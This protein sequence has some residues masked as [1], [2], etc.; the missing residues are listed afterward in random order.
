MMSSPPASVPRRGV[1]GRTRTSFTDLVGCTLPLQLAGMGEISTVRLAA[2]VSDAGGLGMLGAAGR[3]AAELG[4]T[5][6]QLSAATSGAFGV[7]FLMPFL[8]VDAV[9]LAASICRVVEFFYGEPDSSLVEI[10]HRAAALAGWQVGSAEEAAAAVRSGCDFVVVQ[11]IEA[12]GHI[13]GSDPLDVV[14]AHTAGKLPVPLVAAGGIGTAGDVR[15]ALEHGASAVR[16]G[17]R[18]IA[19]IECGAHPTYVEA[20]IGAD[21]PDT[22]LTSDFSAG[23]PNAPHRVLKSCVHAAK[24]AGPGPDAFRDGDLSR[25]ISRFSSSCPNKH[26]TGNVAAMALYAGL[27]VGAVRGRQPAT[28]IVTELSNEL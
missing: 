8:D 19:A 12:G 24:I 11:G 10:V 20:L 26:V 17:T 22:V 15:A 13:R 18:F 4:P 21:A 27:S 1:G 16:V 3:S 23:W 25:P 6:E 2:A 14:L 9:A 7:N 28:E 5:L